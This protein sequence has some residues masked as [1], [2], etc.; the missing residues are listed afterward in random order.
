MKCKIYKDRLKLLDSY[1]CPKGKY[2]RELGRIRNLHPT[3]PV[4]ERTE[5]SLRCEIATH[6]LLYNL[7]IKRSK[8][9]DCDLNF[10]QRWYEKVGYGILGTFALLVVK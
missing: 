7:G 1:L 2:G 4:W 6:T 3:I 5:R 10:V 8:T 9:K